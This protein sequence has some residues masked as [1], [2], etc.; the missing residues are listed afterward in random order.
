MGV[1][2]PWCYLSVTGRLLSLVVRKAAL[3]EPKQLIGSV[4]TV[5]FSV[6]A[7]KAETRPHNR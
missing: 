6:L 4:L 2:S 7:E 1:V 5:S 3:L